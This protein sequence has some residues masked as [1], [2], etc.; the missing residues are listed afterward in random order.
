MSQSEEK[1]TSKMIDFVPVN[2]MGDL[3]T[4]YL[5]KKLIFTFEE[6]SHDGYDREG[7]Q[8]NLFDLYVIYHEHKKYYMDVWHREDWFLEVEAEPFQLYERFEINKEFVE[9]TLKK[10]KIEHDYRRS[11]DVI[12]IE[13]INI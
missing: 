1:D 9:D 6:L 7:P 13:S 3:V 2:L 11:K 8:S 10:D 5:N 4:H 12:L